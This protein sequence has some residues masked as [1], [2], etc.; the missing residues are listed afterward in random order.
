MTLEDEIAQIIDSYGAKFYDSEIVNENGRDI[1]RIYITKDGGVDLDICAKISNDISPLLDINSPLSGAYYLEVSSPGIER[2][3]KKPSHFQNSIGE[4]VKFK[5]V[6]G[7]KLK[8]V[9][10][11][12]DNSSVTIKVKDD[13]RVYKY[14]D[15]LKAKTYF[16]WTK[17]KPK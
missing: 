12:A 6:D 7:D 5:T 15:I 17:P 16:D 8:G 2:K 3:L 13:K 4:L 14:S 11:S 1:Y 9:I 10:D